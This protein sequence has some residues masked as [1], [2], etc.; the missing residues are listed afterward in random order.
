LADAAPKTAPVVLVSGTSTGTRADLE[1]LVN[2]LTSQ[3]GS[4]PVS[5]MVV[6]LPYRETMMQWWH[7]A[8]KTPSQSHRVGHSPDAELARDV[9]AMSRGRFFDRDLP[10]DGIHRLLTAFDD[11]HRAGQLRAISI[12]AMGGKVNEK[13]RTATAFVHRTSRFY[14]GLAYAL[15]D[16]GATTH[17]HCAVQTALNES[18][19]AMDPYS[20]GESFQNFMDPML[21]DWRTAYYGEN[22]ARLVRVKRRYDPGNL[23][24]SPQSIAV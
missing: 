8:G 6:S 1:T 19:E 12:R 2:E 22:Y 9:W 3:V 10:A 11:N 13:E 18:F 16:P 23:F 21:D 14:V 17:D 24:N 4:A 15:L 20:N 7:C 5:R